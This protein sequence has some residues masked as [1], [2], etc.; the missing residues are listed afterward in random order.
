MDAAAVVARILVQHRE[1]TGFRPGATRDVHD[2][3]TAQRV[4]RAA[5]S[6]TQR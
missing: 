5:L 2:R 4:I 1:P 3:H 6:R